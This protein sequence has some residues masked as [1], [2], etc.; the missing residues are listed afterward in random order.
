VAPVRRYTAQDWRGR[1]D[2]RSAGRGNWLSTG[3]LREQDARL[4]AGFRARLA[5]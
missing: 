3:R 1:G 5:S 2:L 4:S